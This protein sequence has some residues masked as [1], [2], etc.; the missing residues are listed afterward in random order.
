MSITA[1]LFYSPTGWY[2]YGEVPSFQ[3]WCTI[4][5][6]TCYRT[7]SVLSS[8][9]SKSDNKTNFGC[10]IPTQ[11][12]L[13]HWKLYKFIIGKIYICR[14]D[15]KTDTRQSSSSIIVAH[16]LYHDLVMILVV[17]FSRSIWIY[18]N[19]IGS[20]CKL[21]E[22]EVFIMNYIHQ[23]STESTLLNSS[24]FVVLNTFHS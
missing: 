2:W 3:R 9:F 4:Y 17:D 6:N 13:N 18:Y 15:L 1:W 22:L 11:N 8:S 12:P 20:C 21:Y 10:V 24:L 14:E 7:V 23:Q 16:F 19:V 5:R